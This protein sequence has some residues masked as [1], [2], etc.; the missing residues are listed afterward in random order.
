VGAPFAYDGLLAQ[1]RAKVIS[2]LRRFP[3]IGRKFLDYPP[4]SVEA[5]IQLSR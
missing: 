3:R 2:D 5:M 4:Q 1:L